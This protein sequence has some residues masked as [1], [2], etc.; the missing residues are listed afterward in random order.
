MAIAWTETY[1]SGSIVTRRFVPETIESIINAEVPMLVNA[2]DWTTPLFT[3]NEPKECDIPSTLVN[4]DD[5]DW[6]GMRFV[7]CQAKFFASWPFF[8]DSLPAP[9][10]AERRDMLLG[11]IEAVKADIA[12][13][14][15][16][17]A[18]LEAELAAMPTKVKPAIQ[19]L[20]DQV[21]MGRWEGWRA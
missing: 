19:G 4:A 21:P 7:E 3:L 17:L 11:S 5:G 16:E 20:T 14:H 2:I 9:T 10:D 13:F 8:V 12:G 6:S 15:E 1:E 18:D